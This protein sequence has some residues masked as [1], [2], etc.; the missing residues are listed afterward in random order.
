MSDAEETAVSEE[1]EIIRVRDVMNS[2]FI[3]VDGLETIRSAVS[4]LKAVDA[5]CLIVNRRHDDDE[6]GLVL[7]SDVAKQVIARDRS[8][9]RVNV[10][11]VM[12]KPVVS[13]GPD[14]NIR[15]AAR[16]FDSFGMAMAPVLENGEIVGVV[17]YS[18]IVLRGLDS[19]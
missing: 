4:R 5:R 18:E 15:Y 13:V 12:S 7:L 14:M 2:R 9:D 10:Y 1:R 11:E 6:Y 3:L 19:L 8:P 16:M 17:T